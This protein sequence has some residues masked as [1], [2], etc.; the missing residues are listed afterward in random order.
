MET[1]EKENEV[2]EKDKNR[3]ETEIEELK[4]KLKESKMNREN[5][6]KY[7][8]ETME[9]REKNSKYK[10]EDE[11]NQVYVTEISQYE[12]E[13]SDLM[14]QINLLNGED[15]FQAYNNIKNVI[16][17]IFS[18]I[19]ILINTIIIRIIQSISHCQI[20]IIYRIIVIDYILLEKCIFIIS[21]LLY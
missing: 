16:I 1:A 4:D 5:I 6:K 15:K 14:S 19:F 12:N 10:A 13:K 18:Y 2:L 17:E 7:Q 21:C 3:N 11:K 20:Q 9:L 8:K